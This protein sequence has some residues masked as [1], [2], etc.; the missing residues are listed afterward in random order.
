MKMKHLKRMMAGVWAAVFVAMSGMTAL[1]AND[2]VDVIGSG[3][4][5]SDTEAV[6]GYQDKDLFSNMKELMPGDT[7]SNTVVLSNK[8]RRG[9]SIYVK[10]YS[11]FTSQDG[12]TAV[13]GDSVVT[14]EGKTFR[15]DILDQI[16]MTLTLGDTVIYRGSADGESPEEG[17][18]SMA[19]GDYGINLGHF[20]SGSTQNLKIELTL[21]GPTFDNSFANT[22][23]AVDWVF[24]VEGTTPGSSGGG[25]GGG[26]GSTITPITD[27]EIPLGPWTGD[28]GDSNIVITDPDVPLGMLPKMGDSGI[29]GY[30]FGI[31]LALVAASGSLYLKKRL[32]RS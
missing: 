15:G 17:F 6:I 25:G 26:N 23:D 18:Q 20:A 16:T 21:P 5:A 4:Y 1:A 24:C 29:H 31:L 13:R 10:A 11:G 28:G 7:V 12:I 8:S 3:R 19:A 27:S 22:F 32:N 9:V 14:A 30:V 2:T